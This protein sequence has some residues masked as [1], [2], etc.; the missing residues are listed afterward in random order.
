MGGPAPSVAQLRT[1]T[2][3]LRQVN[4]NWFVKGQ[5]SIAAFNPSKEHDYKASVDN[6]DTTTA[7]DSY[8]HH[9]SKGLATIGVVAVTADEA[10]CEN[11]PVIA[12]PVAGW[13]H[14][15]VLDFDVLPDKPA[16]RTAARFLTSAARQ[17]GWLHNPLGHATGYA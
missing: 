10:T 12:A 2:L 5:L 11:L 16:R 6:G 17:R 7:R 3:L 14:H 1:G 8:L 15:M 9:Q 13:P 4:P